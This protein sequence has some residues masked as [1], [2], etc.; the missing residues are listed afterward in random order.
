MQLSDRIGR[1]REATAESPT[2]QPRATDYAGWSC[3]A[4]EESDAERVGPDWLAGK[5]NRRGSWGSSQPPDSNENRCWKE[6]TSGFVPTLR[7]GEVRFCAS[8]RSALKPS[9]CPLLS[10]PHHTKL[11]GDSARRCQDSMFGRVV[12]S[13]LTTQPDFAESAV[14]VADDAAL[15]S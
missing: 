4:A 7:T 2:A 14:S 11:V 8:G 12:V 1:R 9:V 3:H 13:P 10:G 15:S 5:E 6:I